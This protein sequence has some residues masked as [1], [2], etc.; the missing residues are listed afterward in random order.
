MINLSKT[1]AE[2]RKIA[3]EAGFVLAENRQYTDVFYREVKAPNTRMGRL[4]KN[5]GY[6]LAEQVTVGYNSA[7]HVSDVKLHTPV[8]QAALD[9]R[10]VTYTAKKEFRDKGKRQAVKDYLLST[11]GFYGPLA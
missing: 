4:A 5:M 7:G 1:R 10:Y 2:N 11:S 6:H 3:E 9:G 8:D